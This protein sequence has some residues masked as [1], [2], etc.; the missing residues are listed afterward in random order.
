MA[1]F[2][3]ALWNENGR[4]MWDLR[5]CWPR[6]GV[7]CLK[8]LGLRFSFVGSSFFLGHVC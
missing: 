5:G 6:I 8:K 3:L 4:Q 7:H 2:L 1:F